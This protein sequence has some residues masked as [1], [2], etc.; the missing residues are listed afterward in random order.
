[1]TSKIRSWKK[2]S[3]Y[4]RC[5][6]QASFICNDASFRTKMH[7]YR[8]TRRAEFKSEQRLILWARC[9]KILVNYWRLIKFRQPRIIRK[10]TKHWNAHIEHWRNT[11]DIT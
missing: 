7:R 3:T 5:N 4:R 8:V 2:T 6:F 10:A 1:M 9:L 11:S